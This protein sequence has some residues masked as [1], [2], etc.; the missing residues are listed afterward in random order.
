ME[1]QDAHELM[2]FV[3]NTLA[4]ETEQFS[5]V[6]NLSSLRFFTEKSSP[7]ICTSLASLQSESTSST[8]LSDS[9]LED[10]TSKISVPLLPQEEKVASGSNRSLLKRNPFV[11]ILQSTLKCSRCGHQFPPTYQKFADI[12]LS[13]PEEFL[14][15]NKQRVCT[16]EDCIKLFTAA[17]MVQDVD[18]EGC[19]KR[20]QKKASFDH[21]APPRPV[22][23]KTSALKK[24]SIARPPKTLCLHIRRLIGL[25]GPVVK[26]N[27]HIDFPL[28]LDLAP[29]CS[30]NGEVAFESS[31]VKSIFRVESGSRDNSRASTKLANEASSSGAIVGG[32]PLKREE[33]VVSDFSSKKNRTT[34]GRNGTE[35]PSLLYRLVSV[36]VHHG[37]HSGGHYTAYRQ[38][39]TEPFSNHQQYEEYIKQSMEDPNLKHTES[40]DWIHISDENVHRVSVDEVLRSQAYMLYY[41]KMD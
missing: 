7:L 22:T 13:I 15:Y 8:T 29:F 23:E 25:G 34:K 31:L 16:L 3:I 33:Q 6:P 5:N 21:S 14:R 4:D 2:Q 40:Q 38:L 35:K 12:S 28:E 26:L 19:K 17:E 9:I 18:C 11:G 30:F 10:Q 37:N 36:I 41:E 1:Q 39:L 27:C 32:N 24:M 20:V